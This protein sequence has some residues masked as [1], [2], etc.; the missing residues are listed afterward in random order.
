MKANPENIT[1][2]FRKHCFRIPLYQRHYDWEEVQCAA[3]WEDFI[4]LYHEKKA[5]HYLG[6]M[7]VEKGELD[8]LLI[9]DGQQRTTSLMLLIKALENF[10]GDRD[11]GF[12]DLTHSG[13]RCRLKPQKWSNESDSC[14]FQAVMEDDISLTAAN[15]SLAANFRYFGNCAADAFATVPM[16]ADDASDALG[17]MWLAFVVLDRQ[18]DDRDNPQTIFDKINSEGKNLEVHDLIRNHLFMLAAESTV[19]DSVSPSAKQQSLYE[20]E[21]QNVEREFPERGL[22]QM[23]HFFR[24]YLIV[25]T[26]DLDLTSGPQLYPRFKKYLEPKKSGE[27]LFNGC[28]LNDF[29]TVEYLTN[30]IWKHAD[31]WGKVVF[32]NP[33]YGNKLETKKLQAALAD[34]SMIGNSL[35]HPLAV[36]LML[37]HG[38]RDH[39]RLARIFKTLNVFITITELTG[40]RSRFRSELLKQILFEG[41]VSVQDWITKD[42]G[43][44]RFRDRLRLLWPPTFDPPTEIGRALLGQLI[45]EDDSEVS[46]E[47]GTYLQTQDAEGVPVAQPATETT[48]E[49]PDF[50][51]MM[52]NVALFLLLKVN[53]RYMCDD[54]DS[55]TMFLE[56]I[57]SLE[58]IMPQTLK[59]GWTVLD[60]FHQTHL[61]SIGN[62]TLLGKNFN[63]TVSNKQLTEKEKH[64]R[65]SSYAITRKVATDLQKAGLLGE[66][67]KVDA[68]LFCEF[69]DKRAAEF[70]TAAKEVLTF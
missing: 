23:S 6:T 5:V 15:N 42:E 62:L 69:V 27:L 34:F 10:S 21:W 39:D 26:G 43:V 25:K 33:L 19:I 47:V 64:Y 11:V 49:M 55:E 36:L 46:N 2:L 44:G 50:Y 40:C 13:A 22:R 52:R 53:E 38:R 31:A 56:P 48:E 8:E 30:D 7:V 14:W 28:C 4:R 63:S 60:S 70:T 9:V 59:D 29:N 16:K 35:Y 68:K 3:L 58:H 61:N 65:N 12:R 41:D 20:N 1:E 54:G 32:C 57:H 24:D 18:G 66:P 17:R 37:D 67:G 51:H 45:P